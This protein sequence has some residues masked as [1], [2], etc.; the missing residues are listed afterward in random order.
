MAPARQRITDGQAGRHC[1]PR[2]VFESKGAF[3]KNFGRSGAWSGCPRRERVRK[4]FRFPWERNHPSVIKLTG[5]G[6]RNRLSQR[7][8]VAVLQKYYFH[9]S[10]ASL[11]SWEEGRRSP[12]PTTAAILEQF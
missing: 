1:Y 2:A 10:F 4:D 3:R 12:P 11:R 6:K 7:A 9:L 5:W 8:A